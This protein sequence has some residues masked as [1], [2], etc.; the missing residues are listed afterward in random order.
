MRCQIKRTEKRN[1]Y[2]EVFSRLDRAD[3]FDSRPFHSPTLNFF[4]SL[5]DDEE[6]CLKDIQDFDTFI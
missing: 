5:S 6:N 2:S 3:E 4:N 1:D